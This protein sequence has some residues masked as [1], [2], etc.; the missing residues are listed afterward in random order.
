MPKKKTAKK[1]K[2]INLRNGRS[3][4][5]IAAFDLGRN[6]GVCV[7]SN[8][9]RC[10][11]RTLGLSKDLGP[12]LS[13]FD[14]FCYQMIEKYDPD[15]IAFERP[16]TP[17]GKASRN[18]AKHQYTAFGQAGALI[19]ISDQFDIVSTA[20]SSNTARKLVCGN[21]RA[22]EEKINRSIARLG[23]EAPDDHS[24]DACVIWSFVKMQI[25]DSDFWP[26]L[27]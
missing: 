19:R 7:G 20:V 22:T 18:S 12:M 2:I 13:A 26:A 5:V 23:F 3:S 11:V 4:A 9:P 15:I 1:N 27:L 14:G 8:I 24:T 21:G 6:V 10:N 17:F 25:K 16:F